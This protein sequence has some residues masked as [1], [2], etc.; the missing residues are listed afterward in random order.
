[1]KH[2]IVQ[3]ENVQRLVE[4]SDALLARGLGMP[5]MG[6]VYGATGYGKTTAATWLVNRHRGVYVRALATSTPSSLLG[7]ILHELGGRPGRSCAQMV[8]QAIQ[9]LV[10]SN[11]PL[12][13][14]EADY[15]IRSTRMVETLRDIH[16]LSTVPVIMIGMA[17]IERAI[18]ERQQLTGRLAQWVQFGPA[19]LA[20]ARLITEQLCEVMPDDRLIERLHRETKGAVRLLIV[21]LGQIEHYARARGQ[22]RVTAAEWPQRRSFFMG[23][24]PDGQQKRPAGRPGLSVVGAD[25]AE[26]AD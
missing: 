15:L 16:D 23:D 14:D 5:G 10:E 11:R 4:A 25:T 18:R 7:G 2:R 3:V 13:I 8:E 12:F 20:D 26:A 6:L 1:M 22:D 24:A 17:G 9:L 21:G 19:S